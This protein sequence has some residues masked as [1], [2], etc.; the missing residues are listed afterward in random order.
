MTLFAGAPV[1]DMIAAGDIRITGDATLLARLQSL[2]T[3]LDPVFP[4]VTP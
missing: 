1:Q 4:I 3:P 2:I